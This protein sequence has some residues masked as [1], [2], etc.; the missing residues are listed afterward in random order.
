MFKRPSSSVFLFLLIF[1]SNYLS[2]DFPFQVKKTT[3]SKLLYINAE[4][5]KLLKEYAAQEYINQKIEIKTIDGLTRNGELSLCR[6]AKALVVLCHYAAGDK[7]DMEMY[8]KSIFS[9]CTTISFDFRRFGEC[10][11]HQCTTFGRDEAYEVEAAVNLLKT[12]PR[13]KKLFKKLPI[14]GFGISMGAVALIEAESKYQL[15]DGL[16][17]QSSYDTLKDQVKR[18]YPIFD[19]PPL[20]AFIFRQPFRGLAYYKYRIKVRKVKPAESIKKIKTPIFLIHALNDNFISIEAFYKLQ[21]NGKSI[22]MTWNP[23]KGEHTKILETYPAL[24]SQKCEEFFQA[25]KE[26][27]LAL[28]KNCS[29]KLSS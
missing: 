3:P 26:R 11:R 10:H 1:T 25:V 14:Y 20:C 28:N 15:F 5:E 2:A 17:L 8:R 13:T 7:H 4:T 23:E 24:Y 9:R 19:G 16:I 22:I 21:Q 12:D 6:D 18:M 27:K 29:Q